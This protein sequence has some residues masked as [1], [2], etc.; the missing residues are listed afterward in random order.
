MVAFLQGSQLHHHILFF[1]PPTLRNC[2]APELIEGDDSP[3]VIEKSPVKSI[4]AIDDNSPVKSTC[5]LDDT[6]DGV[7]IAASATIE[8]A[9]LS[10]S[11]Q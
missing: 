8:T 10:L 3:F 6:G 4:C 2:E 5:A 7:D 11:L 9:R 1:L